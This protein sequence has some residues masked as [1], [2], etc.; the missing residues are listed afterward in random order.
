MQDALRKAV[1]DACRA[2]AVAGQYIKYGRVGHQQQKHQKDDNDK[3]HYTAPKSE[4]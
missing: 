2:G 1:G 4:G 3:A